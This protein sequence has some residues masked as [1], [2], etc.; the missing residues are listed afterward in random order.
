MNRT[1]LSTRLM[2]P[3]P[4][5][6]TVLRRELFQKLDASGPVSYTHLDVYKRQ[7]PPRRLFWGW[8]II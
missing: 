6:G 4:R 8:D 3:K 2:M 5:M 7:H 1:L